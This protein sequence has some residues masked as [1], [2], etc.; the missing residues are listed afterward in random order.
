MNEF[1]KQIKKKGIC[2]KAQNI[3][4]ELRHFKDG[5][6]NFIHLSRLKEIV[7]E[8]KKE[9]Y[10]ARRKDEPWLD[11]DPGNIYDWFDKWFRVG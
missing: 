6:P 10:E 3:T 11:G 5:E 4:G 7:D 9:F 2:I 8:T 1:E